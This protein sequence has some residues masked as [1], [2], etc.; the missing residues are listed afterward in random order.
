MAETPRPIMVGEPALD[1]ANRRDSSLVECDALRINAVRV[2]VWDNTVTTEEPADMKR[3]ALSLAV[4]VAATARLTARDIATMTT[5][6]GSYGFT[7]P[8]EQ[9]AMSP[10]KPVALRPAPYRGK[11]KKA[12]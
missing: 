8:F 12:R 6:T 1:K 5:T 3:L 11:W 7:D 10:A 4:M 2:A 9:S